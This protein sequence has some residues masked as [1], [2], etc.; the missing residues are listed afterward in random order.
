MTLRERQDR[1]IEDMAMFDD[2]KDKFDYLISEHESV[3]HS[4]EVPESLTK[5][6]IDNCQSKTCFRAEIVDGC[7]HV[8]GWSNSSIMS[9]LIVCIKRMFDRTP[10]AEVWKTVI[11]YH[12]KT[13]LIHNMT[14]M[15]SAALLEINHRIHVLLKK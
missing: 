12:Q 15:R 14:P 13:G 1:F 8:D 11:N 10:G 4:R 3:S 7:L 9:G 5:Y 6:R 2:W